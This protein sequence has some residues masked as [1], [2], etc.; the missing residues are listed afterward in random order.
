M[1]YDDVFAGAHTDRDMQ[2]HSDQADVQPTPAHP[3]LAHCCTCNQREIEQAHVR[4]ERANRDDQF[5]CIVNDATNIAQHTLGDCT[6]A[7]QNLLEAVFKAEL[8]R[9]SEPKFKL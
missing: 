3:H 8:K 5:R 7:A 4:Q 2:A 6:T 1:G 9:L